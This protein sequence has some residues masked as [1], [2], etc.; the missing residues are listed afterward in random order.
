MLS[1]L[2]RSSASS[3]VS[4]V[5][6]ICVGAFEDSIAA[7]NFSAASGV[8][9][10]GSG[11][12]MTWLPIPKVNGAG[13]AAFSSFERALNVNVG[14]IWSDMLDL[15][16]CLAVGYLLKV[17]GAGS[18]GF[19]SPS[20]E[21]SM[22]SQPCEMSCVCSTAESVSRSSLIGLPSSALTS[23]VNFMC[24]PIREV[25]S[26][27]E[28]WTGGP[29]GDRLRPARDQERSVSLLETDRVAVTDRAGAADVVTARRAR[30][31]VHERSE[32]QIELHRIRCC[33]L[34]IRQRGQLDSRVAAP[35]QPLVGGGAVSH[36]QQETVLSESRDRGLVEGDLA[37]GLRGLSLRQV[38]TVNE[39][40]DRLSHRLQDRELHRLGRAGQVRPDR[41]RIS[42][43]IDL[44]VL[45]IGGERDAVGRDESKG[46][47]VCRDLL[48]SAACVGDCRRDCRCHRGQ[49][50][51]CIQALTHVGRAVMLIFEGFDGGHASLPFMSVDVILR[52]ACA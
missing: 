9:L 52:L 42:E 37:R 26:M 39:L 5:R 48:E 47:E 24:G 13:A 50:R 6:I 32:F 41:F 35:D 25:I 12:L 49:E 31:L 51:E 34:L 20:F 45:R 22:T 4:Q 19:S 1:L 43:G 3:A 30:R 7:M 38:D 36:D 33:P 18:V 17:G 46:Q 14:F 28:V 16:I 23:F 27:R 2:S 44:F 40:L 8:R 11:K 10:S 15:L 21:S 29:E